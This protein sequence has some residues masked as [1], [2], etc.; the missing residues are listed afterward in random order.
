MISHKWQPI[1]PLSE[2]DDH[3]KMALMRLDNTNKVWNYSKLELSG[4]SAFCKFLD[5]LH[6][7]I[8]IETGIIEGLYEMDRGLTQTLVVQG[9]SRDAVERAGDSIPENT[10]LMLRDQLDSLDYI[11]DFIGRSRELSSAYIR[12]LHAL[13]TRSQGKYTAQNQF[14]QLVER[15]LVSGRYKTEPNNPIRQSGTV[16]EYAPVEQVASEMDRMVDMF[17]SCV[18]DAHPIVASAWLHHRFVQIH[19]FQDGNGRVARALAS[20]VLLRAKLFPLHIRRK[21]RE[22]YINAL[23]EADRGSLDSLV[24][25]FAAREREDMLWAVSE[26]AREAVAPIQGG[27]TADVAA[28]VAGEYARRRRDVLDQ[29][30]QVNFVAE[31]LVEDG[32]KILESN[33]QMAGEA[34]AAQDIQFYSK[35]DF[36]GSNDQRGYWWQHQIVEAAK[37]LNHWANIPENKYWICSRIKLA[38]VRMRFVVSLHHVG[39]PVSGIMAAV[40]FAEIQYPQ[41]DPDDRQADPD[42]RQAYPDDRQE[43]EIVHCSRQAFTFTEHDAGEDLN[44]SFEDWLDEAQAVALRVL[45]AAA[46]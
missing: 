44:R 21:D 9:F 43:Q 23:E 46:I 6:R 16:H 7:S 20:I 41:A 45:G 13:I 1:A 2:I 10:L 29:R 12:D 5:K 22:V 24:Q 36:G 33:L 42:D 3:S 27:R 19:P 37:R 15:D 17:H 18:S 31:A 40:A 35:A 11:M 30:R 25:L 14:G 26:L 28:A 34:F 4:S 32:A 8:A 38:D 39:S